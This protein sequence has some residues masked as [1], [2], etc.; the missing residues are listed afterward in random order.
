MALTKRKIMEMLYEESKTRIPDDGWASIRLTED[1]TEAGY[2]DYLQYTYDLRFRTQ[3]IANTRANLDMRMDSRHKAAH[4]IHTEL[5]GAL[6]NDMI[7]LKY[8]MESKSKQ[9]CQKMLD[10]IIDKLIE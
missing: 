1:V 2:P 9:E 3:I 8:M 7:H 5:Y 4:Q 10:G 6:A